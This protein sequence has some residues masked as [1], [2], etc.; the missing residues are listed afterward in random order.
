MQ[1][2]HEQSGKSQLT[3]EV[4]VNKADI[5]NDVN[6]ALRDY[7]RK[8]AMPGFRPGKVP[9]GM[10][11]KM[12][13]P[14]M[15]AEQMN[16]A[17]S[18]ALNDYINDNNLKILGYPIADADRTGNIDFDNSSEFSFYFDAGLSPEIDINLSEMSI[19]Y[20]KVRVSE[21]E[22]DTTIDKMREDYPSTIYPET[23]EAEDELELKLAE[24]DEAGNEIAEGFE[25]TIVLK[26]K[27]FSD[28]EIKEAFV[29]KTDGSE[30]VVNFAKYLS[31]E[32]IIKLLDLYD[33]V[34]AQGLSERNFNVVITMITRTQKS[35]LNEEFFA[36]V[37]QNEEVT[38][39]ADFR[40]RI[41]DEIQKHM[42]EQSKYLVYSI[43]LKKIIDET[44][45]ELPHGFMKR[46][47]M[48]N[49]EGAITTDDIEKN[50]SDYEKSLRFQ[51]IED[52][53]TQKY[54]ELHVDKNEVRMF[55]LQHFFGRMMGNIDQM[56]DQM[57]ERMLQTVDSLLKNKKEEQ[58]IV[59]QLR[60]RKLVELFNKQLKLEEKEMT[61]DEFKEFAKQNQPE[62]NIESYE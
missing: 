28:T 42:D 37:F 46:W 1:V 2:H 6:K 48:D 3:I 19:V 4:K 54:P 59:S 21:E 29:G 62:E 47:I 22:I 50:Y 10:V 23:V 26:L 60:E 7:Q 40:L 43:A 15:M 49:S 8:V 18:T 20:P 27:E 52:H 31:T 32:Q 53:L 12:Y 45:M 13:G 36:R 33:E 11:K 16:K 14:S 41:G 30:F 38:T 57:K 9:F 44:V 61:Q 56:D 24:A 55:V 34:D 58:Q 39:E 35:E 25:S 5:E 51:L 17:V